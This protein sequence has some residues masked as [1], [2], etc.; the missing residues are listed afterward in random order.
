MSI[1]AAL[2]CLIINKDL[3]KIENIKATGCRLKLEERKPFTDYISELTNYEK[4]KCFVGVVSKSTSKMEKNGATERET[5]KICHFRRGRDA[6]W[7]FESPS[8]Q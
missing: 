7:V 8:S 4:F 5:T 6:P 1:E 2:F 3:S